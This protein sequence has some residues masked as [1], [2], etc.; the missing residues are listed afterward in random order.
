[1]NFERLL[2]GDGLVD[3]MVL[4][5]GELSCAKL[6]EA[7]LNDRPVGDVQA[8]PGAATTEQSWPPR[9]RC[10]FDDLPWLGRYEE[11]AGSVQQ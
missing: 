10:C 4:G 11:E 3:Y 8:W 9:R 2:R 5:E 7:V 6:A 1:M